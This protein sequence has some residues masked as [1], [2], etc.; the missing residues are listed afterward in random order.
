MSDSTLKKS[1]QRMVDKPAV[2]TRIPT[3]EPRGAKPATVGRSAAPAG[4]TTNAGTTGDLVE[5][6]YTQREW[7]PAVV[8]TSSD[9]SITFEER[10]V[11]SILLTSGQRIITAQPT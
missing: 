2:G 6:D 11:K 8:R 4:S 7:W 1:V 9:G 5:A 3:P 10:E